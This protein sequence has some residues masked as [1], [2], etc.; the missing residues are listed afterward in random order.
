MKKTRDKNL[1]ERADDRRLREIDSHEEDGE[2][3]CL[4]QPYFND[5]SYLAGAAS[6]SRLRNRRVLINDYA[7]EH[8]EDD[9]GSDDG[10]GGMQLILPD[11]EERLARKALDRI[12]SAHISGKKN[13]MLTEFEYDA[14]ESKRERDEAARMTEAPSS[15]TK[16]R[17]HRGL[18][19]TEPARDQRGS[20]VRIRSSIPNYDNDELPRPEVA[21]PLGI[22]VPGSNGS[23]SYRPYPDSAVSRRPIYRSSR[24]EF[25]SASF[26]SQQSN[27]LRSSQFYQPEAGN[28]L[29]QGAS[30]L[31]SRVHPNH[32]SHREPDDHN[33]TSWPRSASSGTYPP[34]LSQERPIYTQGVRNSSGPTEIYSLGSRRG[35]PPPMPHPSSEPSLLHRAKHSPTNSEYFS[36]ND[37]GNED[38]DESYGVQS[39]VAPYNQS[40]GVIGGR[41]GY[42]RDWRR[43]R[44][45]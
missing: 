39:N 26:H 17:R 25:G 45:R 18:R 13:V 20:S 15:R 6:L 1:R 19:L 3:F 12:R 16:G 11:E 29:A 42:R 35:N 14:L 7:S 40:Y 24:T 43:R 36:D 9:Y 21:T 34:P 22:L 5:E 28:P 44:E 8:S 38:E 32:L 4:D 41:E 2:G 37:D 30:R 23:Q 31:S 10:I 33:W 27:T